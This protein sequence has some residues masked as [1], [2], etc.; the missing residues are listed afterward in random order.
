MS[1]LLLASAALALLQPVPLALTVN[2]KDGDVLKG[3]RAFR[4][5]VSAETAINKVEFYVNGDLR[6]T[7][8]STPYE[9][10][11]D[12]VGEDDG[13]VKLRFKAYTVESKSG[14]KA[15]SAKI[16][17]ELAK[18]A[19]YHVEKANDLLSDG[20]YAEARDEG[21]IALKADKGSFDARVALA[22]A[23][24]GLGEYDQAQLQAEEAK[25]AKPEDP[26]ALSLLAGINVQ[27]AFR[28]YAKPDADRAEVLKG[29]K[30]SLSAAVAARRAA[31]DV[32]FDAL[33]PDPILPYADAALRARR[34]SAAIAALTPAFGA[35]QKNAAIADRLAYAYLRT[36]RRQDA[37]NVLATLARAGS[38]SAYGYALKAVAHA[39]AGDDNLSDEAI[40]EAILADSE[41][42]GVR[43]AQAYIALKRNKT[44]VLAGL[45][46]S[47]AKEQ[48]QR[49]DVR[50]FQ[51][52]LAAKQQ[53]YS[54]A[55]KAFQVGV[56]AEPASADLYVE[57]ANDAIA[58]TQRGKMDEKEKASHYAEARAYFET[59]LVARPEASEALAGL[60]MVAAFEGKP[61]EAVRYAD[62]AVRAAPMDAGAYYALAAAQS[63][64]RD[65]A[66]A[67]AAM[68]RA[69][70]ARQEVPRRPPNPR[71]G[72]GLALPR[73]R[74]P[75][76]RHG[77]AQRTAPRRL[78]GPPLRSGLRK[79]RSPS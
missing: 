32:G 73:H 59:A 52:A 45:S 78:K 76:H 7:D 48:G 62:A 79:R 70:A 46:S 68:R 9:F 26:N 20:K 34:Y 2:A 10:K 28:T 75:P 43:T 8:T 29:I 35:D 71:R 39:D 47:L 38:L 63:L 19:A 56:L 33:K 11:L 23:Y 77:R 74:R 6:D 31:L 21:R 49:A 16:D 12:T 54:D 37:L 72:G 58:I 60:A 24:S 64:N 36:N 13:P 50:Y 67:Q 30:D 66:K 44:D 1:V 27:R 22:R 18:G 14:E 42:L 4:V 25:A 41:D 69:D 17:N 55:T 40:R 57:Y 5:S 65:V 3:E 53:R 15:V 51:M 61:A